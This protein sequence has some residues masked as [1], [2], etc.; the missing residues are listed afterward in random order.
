VVT[1]TLV[2]VTT[3]IAA[4]PSEAGSVLA[5]TQSGLP[6]ALQAVAIAAA[7]G[8]LAPAAGGNNNTQQALRNDISQLT[9]AFQTLLQQI[10]NTAEIPRRSTASPSS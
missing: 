7:Q 9:K 8:S 2:T 10:T 5:A 6:D 1:V 3:L 4:A